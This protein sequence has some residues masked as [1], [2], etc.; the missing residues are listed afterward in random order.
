[1]SETFEEQW[2]EVARYA[3]PSDA[4]GAAL[5]L[6]AAGIGS[7]LVRHGAGVSV[8]VVDADALRGAHELAEYQQENRRRPE[9]PLP[10]LWLGADAAFAYATVLI[11][12]YVATGREMFGFDWEAAG[13][14]QSALILSGEWW[15]TVTALTLHADLGHL[16]SNVFAGGVFGMLLAQLLGPGLT[17]LAIVVAGGL[18]NAVNALIEPA[19]HTSI[20]ASTSVFAALGLFVSLMW[21][22]RATL[23][24]RGLRTWLPL[25][26]GAMLLAFL[27]FGGER[28]DFGAHIAG[29]AI[30]ILGGV[31][32]HLAAG[33]IPQG[34]RAQYIYGAAALALLCVSWFSALA[35]YSPPA[36][37]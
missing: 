25:A 7:R 27:G 28:T 23:W 36:G 21:R 14:A 31:A 4:E 3:R 20:G 8:L 2:T 29:F 11:I 6:A 33:L 10:S 16:A 34:R 1:L 12:V 32:L 35:A 9:P 5:V 15:R 30:G 13:Y 18:G 24:T 37:Q 22:R 17:W 19:S 26:A